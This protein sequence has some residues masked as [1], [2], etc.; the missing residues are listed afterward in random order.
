MALGLGGVEPW[1]RSATPV[2]LESVV[3][4]CFVLH[5]WLKVFPLVVWFKATI[6][7]LSGPDK[8]HA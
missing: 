1:V 7:V 8:F 4:A 6:M 5:H 3:G 2:G